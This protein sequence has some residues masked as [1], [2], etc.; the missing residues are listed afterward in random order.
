[1]VIFQ[2]EYVSKFRLSTLGFS[3]FFSG[4]LPSFK[5][6]EVKASETNKRR[7]SA[8]VA[9]DV[10]PQ[11][12]VIDLT[13]DDDHLHMDDEFCE[14]K[15]KLPDRKSSTDPNDETEVKKKQNT[16]SCTD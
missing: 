4:P 1:M 11:M 16:G 15:G 5:E 10:E 2:A 7:P 14:W 13:E 6:S 9:S 8:K 3:N 12:K